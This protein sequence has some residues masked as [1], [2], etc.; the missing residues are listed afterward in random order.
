MMEKQQT[1]VNVTE[2]DST[3]ESKASA[4]KV[5]SPDDVDGETNSYQQDSE[6]FRSEGEDHHQQM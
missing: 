6:V 4:D 5:S 1:L 3:D 2:N